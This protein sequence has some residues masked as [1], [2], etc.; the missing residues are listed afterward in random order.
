[1][2]QL[3]ML[4]LVLF[5]AILLKAGD[6]KK[7]DAVDTLR[8]NLDNRENELTIKVER[9]PS[10][11]HP[12]FVFWIEDMYG[13]FKQ[14][15]LVTQY[16][17]TG[18]FA[19]GPTSDT[20]WGSGPGQA[21]R[22][23]ALPYWNHKR[24]TQPEIEKIVPGKNDPI[25]DAITAATPQG[26]FVL[27]TSTAGG[28]DEKYRL[29]FEINQTWDWNSFWTNNKFPGNIQYKTSSQPSVVYAVTIDP[30]SEMEEYWMNPIGHGHYDGSNGNLFT[31]LSTLSTAL[32]IVKSI[33]V[34]VKPGKN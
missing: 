2:R 20:T 14:T 13:D 5:S 16:I 17:A 27:K 29:L 7:K 15:L 25:P 23:A 4:S 8:I 32:E 12:T 21:Y 10:H 24:R 3:A 18:E 28:K 26:S 33:Q 11:N 22:P 30:R 31:N 6:N 9:G 34:T 19:Y 1:M